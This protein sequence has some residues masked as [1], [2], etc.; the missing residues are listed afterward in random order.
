M[1]MEHQTS[2]I[3][4]KTCYAACLEPFIY[5][6]KG[7]DRIYS[8]LLAG[9]WPAIIVADGA[10]SYILPDG[11]VVSG[12]GARVAALACNYAKQFFDH[13]LESEVTLNG[14]TRL[15]KS[16]YLNID[17]VLQRENSSELADQKQPG[18]TT[19]LIAFLY[20]P[21]Y[22]NPKPYWCYAYLGDGD[23]VLMNPERKIQGWVTEAYLSTPHT[24]GEIT[25][26]LPRTEQYEN[27][28]PFIGCVPYQIGDILYVA[29]DGLLAIRKFIGKHQKITFGNYLWKHSF[30]NHPFNEPSRPSL[31]NFF[32]DPDLKSNTMGLRDTLR[33]DVTFSAIWTKRLTKG[34]LPTD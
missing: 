2:D 23:I 5:S 33:D 16:V 7:E 28:E 17:K 12:G 10:S 4:L 34:E 20:E 9:R 6:L 8:G 24:N 3:T 1:Q 30:E 18:A 31:P 22:R 29:S 11:Q 21:S 27:F 32:G 13:H 15:L 26:T 19:L 14:L 25:I